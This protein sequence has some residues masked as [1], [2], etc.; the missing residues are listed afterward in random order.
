MAGRFC[1][2]KRPKAPEG[3]VRETAPSPLPA[4][5]HTHPLTC[6][7][8][9]SHRSHRGP[10]RRPIAR[11]APVRPQLQGHRLAHIVLA[12]RRRC[13]STTRPASPTC[14]QHQ[15]NAAGQPL[16]Y[17]KKGPYFARVD[18]GTARPR[19][20]SISGQKIFS[21]WCAGGA[22]F[23]GRDVGGPGSGAENRS[24]GR[25]ASKYHPSDGHGLWGV[26]AWPGKSYKSTPT[27]RLAMEFRPPK[28][29][30]RYPGRIGGGGGSGIG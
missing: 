4:K 3:V 10:T 16:G 8:R 17:R 5:G 14:K 9:I 22:V 23:R 29:R 11:V 30:A 24:T 19:N 12:I 20:L 27:G 21:V 28:G 25:R 15:P 2:P 13:R 26:A 6:L 1:A 7:S 18:C